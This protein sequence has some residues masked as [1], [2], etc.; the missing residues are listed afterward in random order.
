VPCSRQRRDEQ[1]VE[2]QPER[3]DEERQAHGR[4]TR[5]RA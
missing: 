4:D 1:D 2:E 3:Q 5:Q